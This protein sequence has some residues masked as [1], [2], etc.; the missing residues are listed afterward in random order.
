MANL[1]DGR[2]GKYFLLGIDLQE[3]QWLGVPT[4][5]YLL[6]AAVGGYYYFKKKR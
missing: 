1:S 3:K 5:G 4:W 6:A 2:K